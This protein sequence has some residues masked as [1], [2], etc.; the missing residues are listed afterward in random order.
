MGRMLKS[1]SRTL[2]MLLLLSPVSAAGTNSYFCIDETSRGL[3]ISVGTVTEQGKRL[4]NEKVEFST[5]FSNMVAGTT[6][7]MKYQCR[8]GLSPELVAC[9]FENG[10]FFEWWS[11][12]LK[13]NTYVHSIVGQTP[14]Y[15]SGTIVTGKCHEL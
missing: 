14:A 3:D 6:L 1:L 2:L 7:P 10:M 9:S 5:D 4:L 8:T 12:N 11:F 15:S 13:L